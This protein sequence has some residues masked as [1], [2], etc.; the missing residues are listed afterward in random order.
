[1]NLERHLLMTEFFFLVNYSF[2][3]F[4]NKHKTNMESH[5]QYWP[6]PIKGG[7][8]PLFSKCITTPLQTF[9]TRDSRHWFSILCVFTQ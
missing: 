8:G 6:S 5:Y 1:M 4:S 3:Y 7:S 9:W 2:N